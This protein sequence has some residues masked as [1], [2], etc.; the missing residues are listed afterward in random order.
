MICT[1]PPLTSLPTFSRGVPTARSVKPSL[2]KSAA[3]VS[4]PK[5]SPAS[6]TPGTPG[7]SWL[8]RVRLELVVMPSAEP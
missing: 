2:L 4:W 6:E 5:P 7:L 3:V 8:M 1:V